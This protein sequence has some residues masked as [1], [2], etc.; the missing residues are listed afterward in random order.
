MRKDIYRFAERILY[1]ESSDSPEFVCWAI[2]N[3]KSRIFHFT[4]YFT[5]VINL[6][7]NIRN[8]R[9]RPALG[10][11]ADLDLHLVVRAVSADPRLIHQYLQPE[12]FAIEKLRCFDVCRCR[13]YNN[14]SYRHGAKIING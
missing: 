1:I 9:A 12:D 14:S 13:V 7:G 10:S 4:V 8:R 5:N 2:D 11:E 6:N 3:R